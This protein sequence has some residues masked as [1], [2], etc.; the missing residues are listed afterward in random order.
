MLIY[1]AD[2]THTGQLVASNTFPLAV[3]LIGANI[4]KEIPSARVELFKYPDDLERGLQRERPDVLGF[5]NYSWN[6][7]LGMAFASRVKRTW[8]DVVVIAGGPNYGSTD[9]EHIDYWNRFGGCVDFYC[10]KEGEQAVVNL[11]QELIIHGDLRYRM[12]GWRPRSMHYLRDG[13]IIK[14][15]LMERVKSLDEL[16]SPYTAGLMDKFFDGVLIPMT[17]TTRGCPFKCSFCTEGTKYYDQVAKRTTLAEDLE[18]IAQRVGKVQDLYITDANFGMFKEDREKAE[19]IAT[20]KLATGW[21][22]YIHVSGGKN[23]KERVLEVARILGGGMGV[24]ASLQSTDAKVL[25]F[26]RRDNISVA[27]LAEVGRR[28]SKIDANTYAE[29]ILNLPGDTVAAHTQS[30]RDAV[31]SGLSYLRM[32]QLILLPETDMNTRETRERFGLKT[33]WRIMPRCFGAYEFQGERFNCAEAEEIVVAQDSMSFEEY[34][35]CRE[36]DLTVQIAHNNNQFR[37]LRGLCEVAGVEWFELLLKFHV[38]RREYLRELYDEFRRQTIAPLWD[39]RDEMLAFAR[40]HLDEYLT[41][42]RGTNEL[43]NANAVAFFQLQGQLHRGMYDAAAKI[44]PQYKDYLAEAEDFSLRRKRDLLAQAA[45]RTA[46]YKYD[47]PAL[48][49]SDFAEDPAKC[50]RDVEVTFAHS[51]EQSETITQLIRQYGTTNT[52]LGRIMLRAHVKRLFRGIEYDGQRT[53]RGFET[54]YRRSTNLGD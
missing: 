6:C 4:L 48:L 51:L 15:D 35:D 19:A 11:I 13:Q 22:K 46:I 5:S 44:F 52:G 31:N 53:E 24:A 18:Y 10:Y 54:S 12:M 28:G 49:E 39:D 45:E 32:Y 26:I 23:H 2:L 1:L 41:E 3:G 27:Q 36:L 42:K 40:D 17:H 30:L 33:K 14:P 34:C 7:Y 25:S 29:I 16:P 20:V 9:E 38:K 50:R 21:P 8:P 43:F 47:F 37:E